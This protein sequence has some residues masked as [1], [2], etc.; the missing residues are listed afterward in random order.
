MDLILSVSHNEIVVLLLI[1]VILIFFGMILDSTPVILLMVPMLLPITREV[2][3]N[4]VHSWSCC[5]SE[6]DDWTDDSTYRAVFIY[7]LGSNGE[8]ALAMW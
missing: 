4:D 2:G 8:N 7:A 6:S 1:N 5:G 3:I